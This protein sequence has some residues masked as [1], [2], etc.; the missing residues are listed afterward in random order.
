[1]TESTVW[2][3]VTAALFTVAAAI[4][5]FTSNP[6]GVVVVLVV[7]L[8]WLTMADATREDLRV[9]RRRSVHSLAALRRRHDS[10]ILE[11]SLA[12]REKPAAEYRWAPVAEP[13]TDEIPVCPPTQ[14]DLKA[15]ARVAP[16]PV[17]DMTWEQ[18]RAEI[19]AEWRRAVAQI[20][21]GV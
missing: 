14:P 3:A 4:G 16:L 6:V 17:V 2:R 21:G 8:A 1:M 15:A 13:P 9:L 12:A 18:R 5:V 7:W 10:E 19:E 20:E 11:A